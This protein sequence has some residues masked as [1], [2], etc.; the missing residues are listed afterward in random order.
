MSDKIVA[1]DAQHCISPVLVSLYFLEKLWLSLGCFVW[2]VC[3]GRTNKD[4]VFSS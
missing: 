4:V 2:N 3:N 1:T